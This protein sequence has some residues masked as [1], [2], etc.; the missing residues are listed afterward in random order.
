MT[1][2]SLSD[3]LEVA[4]PAER[5]WTYLTDWQRHGEWIPLTRVETVGGAARAVGGKVRAWTGVGPL[6]FWDPMTVTAWEEAADGGGRVAFVH[7]GRLVKGDAELVVSA[8]SDGCSHL[9][10]HEEFD[11]SRVS[12]LAWKVGG[13]L[14]QRG[15]SR[16][17]RRM[18]GLVEAS[19]G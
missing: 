17:L 14:L 12:R 16:A 11:M 4:A 2:V 19:G 15:L 6:G 7:T 1:R 13:P 3:E 8:L 9:S 18:A 10:W 5:L